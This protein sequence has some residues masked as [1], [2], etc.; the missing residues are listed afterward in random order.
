MNSTVKPEND[1]AG[2]ATQRP[3]LSR[4]LVLLVAGQ[5]ISL[6]GN[7][8]LRFAMSMWVLDETGS[9]T[10]FASV[11]AISIVPTILL[12]PFGGVLA[13]RVNR[14]TIMVALDAISA[15]LGAFETPTVQAALPQMFRQYGPATMRQGMAVINQVQ[16]L[17]SLLPSFLGGV[18]YAMFGIR[19]MMIIAIASFA[20]A[21]ALECFIRLGAPDRGDEELPTPLEDLKAGVRFLI[22]DR[23]NV[24]R[25]LLFAAA[26]NFVLIGYSGVG[27]PYTIRTV[28]GFDATVYG[29]ADGLIGV[30]GVA[31]AFI[32]GLFAARLT[33]HWMPGLMATLTLAMVPQGIVF[34]LPVD[35]WTK[36]VVLIVFACGTMVASCF[37]NLIAVPAIQ[38]S[39]PEAMTGKVMSMAAAVSMC[40]QPLGQ[41]VY[42]WAYDQMPVAIVLF[43]TTALFAV[44]TALMVP[45]AKQF[46]D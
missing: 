42:G 29:I 43:I 8:M 14:R 22:K 35:A 1:I 28:L 31:G 19:L 10:I 25:L 36:L 9:A 30:S 5:G 16:Q 15:V 32:A 11:L 12:S 46:E 20:G 24:F 3:L 40:A 7:M 34:L 21:A 4:D 38:L 41:M 6:F 18:L 45:L 33:M 26:L 27:F 39:T 17:S 2:T 44:L 13:D 23:P 37:T